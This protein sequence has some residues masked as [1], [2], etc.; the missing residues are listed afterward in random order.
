[1]DDH[2][3]YFFLALSVM[4]LMHLLIISDKTHIVIVITMLSIVLYNAYKYVQ[5]TN[6]NK[7]S[8]NSYVKHL[9]VGTQEQDEQYGDLPDDSEYKSAQALIASDPILHTTLMKL[10]QYRDIDVDVHDSTVRQLMKYY[11]L[12]ADILSGKKEIAT[13]TVELIDARRTILNTVAALYTQLEHSKHAKRINSI[14][15]SIQASTWKCL[16]ILKHKYDV[17]DHISPVASNL[18][19]HEHELF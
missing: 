10:K 15:T 6:G 8:L 9:T 11:D 1:M 3:Y 7:A 4:W 18:V 14:I 19:G 5:D 16:D 17:K 13:H 2:A 12:Y